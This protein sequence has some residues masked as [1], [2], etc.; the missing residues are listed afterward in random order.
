M[1][2]M[3]LFRIGTRGS[4]LALIQTHEVLNALEWHHSRLKD[5]MGIVPIKTTG[6]T[7]VDRSLSDLGGKSLFTKEIEKALLTGTIDLAVHSMKDMAT[8]SPP[9]LTVAAMLER[10]DPRDALI[11]RQ[12]RLLEDLPAGALFGT[13]SLRRQAQVLHKFPHFQVTSLRGNVDTR[14]QKIEKGDIDATLLAV[15]GLKRLGLLKKA[16]QILSLDAYL[17]AVAQGAIGIQCREEDRELLELLTPLNHPPTF[18]AVTAERAFLKALNGSCRTP[19]AA[20]GYIED[21]ILFLKGMISDPQG[22]TMQFVSH[23]GLAAQAETVGNEAA[24]LLQKKACIT[25]S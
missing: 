8:D 6:D 7:I 18:Q 15:A 13:S 14:L 25:S 1:V 11:T 19:I 23:Q 21:K 5:R 17:P 12:G 4:P 9:G 3:R 10:E 22:H 20:Y 16:T 2:S 24:Q